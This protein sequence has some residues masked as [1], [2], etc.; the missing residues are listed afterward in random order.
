MRGCR[1]ATGKVS[2]AVLGPLLCLAVVGSWSARAAEREAIRFDRDIRPILSANC[3]AC[4]GPGK[5]EAGL[6]LDSAESAARE[7][8]SGFRAI[9]AGDVQRSEMLQRIVRQQ[10]PAPRLV[11]PPSVA[12]Q[13]AATV[14]DRVERS[15]RAMPRAARPRAVRD[16]A[17]AQRVVASAIAPR[18]HDEDQ[19]AGLASLRGGR[20]R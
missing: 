13:I 17:P 5:Q 6:R 20:K 12:E 7:L 14:Q 10:P 18:G 15:D 3:Y 1:N 4:H 8:E 9:V 11:E 19:A 2:A 16:A